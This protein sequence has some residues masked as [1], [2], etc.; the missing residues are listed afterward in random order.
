MKRAISVLCLF[1][2]LLSLAAVMTVSTSAVSSGDGRNA[3][4]TP[5]APIVDAEMDKSY[6]H[7]SLIHI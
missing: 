2:M 4:Y 6:L 5:E 1:A 7:L 3:T